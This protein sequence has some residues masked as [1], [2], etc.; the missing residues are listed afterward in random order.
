M[1]RWP[2]DLGGFLLAEAPAGRGGFVNLHY[3]AAASCARRRKW[4][5]IRYESFNII[6]HLA[7]VENNI[8]ENQRLDNLHKKQAKPSG[9]LKTTEIRGPGKLLPRVIHR[10]GGDVSPCPGLHMEAASGESELVGYGWTR[11]E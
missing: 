4:S 5:Q 6:R 11:P 3:P 2:L 8:K 10:N 9:A 7:A 1:T